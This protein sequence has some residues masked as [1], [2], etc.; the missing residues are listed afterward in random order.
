MIKAFLHDTITDV[1]PARWDAVPGDPFSRHAVLTALEEA[2]LP[3]VR[4][5]YAVL[6]DRTGR[7]RAVAPLAHVRLDGKQFAHGPLRQAIERARRIRPELLH[8]SA[9]VVG[10]PLSVGNPPARLDPSADSCLLWSRLSGLVNE[11]ADDAGAPWRAVKELGNE[12]SDSVDALGRLG[13]TLVPSEAGFVLPLRW[14]SFDDYQL[15]LRS[16][17]RYRMRKAVSAFDRRG[18]HVDVLPLA[19][20]YNDELHTLYEG[21]VA[22]APVLF[23]QLTASFFRSFGRRYGAAAPLIRFRRDGRVVGWVAMF[24]AGGNAYDLFHGIDYD[25]N[26]R[27]A[28]YHNQL[29]A[30]VRLAIERRANRLSLGQST[31]EPKLRLGAIPRPLSIALRHRNAVVH[32]ALRAT[33]GTVF[34]EPDFPSHRVFRKAALGIDV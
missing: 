31:A 10:T 6:E 19:E 17:Y 9:M 29:A 21:V 25:E 27:A 13:W 30:A 32:T 4:L 1:D 5:R 34:P 7:W 18:V 15:D 22:R 24:F 20:A 12:D 23:E 2:S 3:G 14:A 33:R 8:T 16:A 28:I 26:A 11:A